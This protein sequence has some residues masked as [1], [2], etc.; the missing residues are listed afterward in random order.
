M[1]LP[2][3]MDELHLKAM[4]TPGVTSGLGQTDR[5]RFSYAPSIQ[6]AV[7]EMNTIYS[8]CPPGLDSERRAPGV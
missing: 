7:Y 8:Y 1:N 5:L 2:N 6:G 3:P 4:E